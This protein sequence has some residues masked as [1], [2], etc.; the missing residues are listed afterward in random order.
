MEKAIIIFLRN[1]EYL[2][3]LMSTILQMRYGYLPETGHVLLSYIL[4]YETRSKKSVPRIGKDS[5][6]QLVQRNCILRIFYIEE[7]KLKWKFISPS[8]T[9]IVL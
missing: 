6:G 4:T 5:G 3:S 7:M 1:A 8:K 9:S 2:L